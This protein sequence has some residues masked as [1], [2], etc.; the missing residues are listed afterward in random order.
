MM[1]NKEIKILL[2]RIFHTIF[3]PV[4]FLVYCHKI[5]HRV[6]IIRSKEKIKI[7]F[8]ISEVASWKTELLY[9]KMLK[10][11]RFTPILGVS[12]SYAPPNEK[13]PL[14]EYL[15]LKG[16]EFEDLDKTNNS[17]NKIAPDII[18]YYKPYS[19][20]YSK[21]HFFDH[22]LKYLFCG[23]DYCIT[24]TKY[25]HHVHK[26]YY[27]YC[28][29][30]FAEHPDVAARK[31][32]VLG[33]LARNVRVT[34]VPMQD[35]LLIDKKNFSDPW[36]CNNFKKRIIY[37]PHH[38]IKGTN[39]DGIEFATFLDFG[40]AIFELAKKYSEQVFFAFKPHPTLYM[41]LLTIWG[42]K[43]TNSYY[44]EWNKLP[45]AQLETGEYVGLFKHSDAIIHDSSSFIIEYLYMNK[46]GMYL[47]AETNN[48]D[49]MYNFVQEGFYCYEHGRTIEQI[50][51]FIKNVING[52]DVKQ[53]Q[54]NQFIKKQLLPPH[55]KTA[56]DNIINAILED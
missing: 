3:D 54:R 34:G 43:R 21:G 27:D 18:F 13:E 46:P 47:V 4:I 33:K 25:I 7:L 22:N 29:L 12:T 53:K 28:W 55:G 17:I 39:G 26:K 8:V 51:D 14:I 35:L 37:A 6:K 15:K 2:S 10:H 5:P 48:I 30:Y 16:Y 44:Q 45:N 41:K 52:T 19:I 56:C 31:K 20:C 36:K 1:L 11:S 24:T 40:E 42:E 23:M 49:N 9:R 50:E 32:E 38:S